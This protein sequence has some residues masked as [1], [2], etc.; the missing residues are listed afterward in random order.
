MI[1]SVCGGGDGMLD[2]MREQQPSGRHFLSLGMMGCS[3]AVP[4]S[5]WWSLWFNDVSHFHPI[6]M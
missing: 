1:G 3:L 5:H 2:E 6:K 4:F